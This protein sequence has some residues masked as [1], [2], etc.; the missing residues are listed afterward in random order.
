MGRFVN[1]DGVIAGIGGVVQGYNLYSY[2]FNNPI[3]R[4]DGSGLWSQ[5]LKNVGNV[6]KK[7]ATS[8]S[9]FF[10]PT[11]NTASGSFQDGIFKGSGSATL[12]Y[13]ESMW[14][15]QIDKENKSDPYMTAGLYGKV[16]V[17]NVSE[18][19]G[20]GNKDVSASIK[21]VGDILTTSLQAGV[22][23][24]DGLGLT[25]KA[26]AAVFSGRATMEFELF[27]WQFEFGVTGDVLSIG[28]EAT[29]GIFDGVYESKVNASLGVGGGFIFR[30][31]PPQ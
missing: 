19:V 11:T 14:R 26:K 8:V 31:K 4:S 21:G 16:S 3:N 25:A 9:N 24:K 5:W 6:I 28:A 17:A 12:G 18:K 20:I 30:A 7:A 22:K 1:S 27:G 10:N 29:I 15:T 13:T 23:Y 2:C